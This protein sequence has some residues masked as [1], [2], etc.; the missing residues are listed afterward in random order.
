M[1]TINK[2]LGL[3]L[4][5]TVAAVSGCSRDYDAPPLNMPVYDGPDANITFTQLQE[6]YKDVADNTQ[7]LID[8]EYVI[9]GRVISSDA[10]G[11]IFKQIYIQNEEGGILLGVDQNNVS[12]YYKL[13]Q[14]VYVNLHGLYAVRYGGELQIGMGDTQANRI[15]WTTFTEH[16]QKDGWPD[17]AKIEP[18]SVQIKDLTD[19]MVNT[20]VKLEN[21]S[22]DDGGKLPFAED[23]MTSNRTVRSADGTATITLRTSGYSNFYKN[24]LPEGYGTLVGVVGKHRGEWQLMLRSYE[25]VIDFKAGEKP[26]PEPEDPSEN[27][28]GN[29]TIAEFAQKYAAATKDNPIKIEEDISLG[30]V[31]ISDDTDSNVFKKV[32][33]QDESGAITLGVDDNFISKAYPRGQYIHIDVKGLDAIIFGGVLQI[34]VAEANA[35]RMPLAEFSKRVS[36]GTSNNKIN[37]IKTSIDQLDGSMVNKLV[38]LDNVYFVDGGTLPYADKGKNVNRDIKDSKGNVLV[39]RNSGYSKFQAEMLPEGAISITGLLD[40]FNG[41]Y[42]LTIRDLNDVVKGG[43]VEPE[44]EPE[45]TPEEGVIFSETFGAKFDKGSSAWPKVGAFT[46]YDNKNVS[47]SDETGN[48]DIRN[49]K[50]LDNHVWLPANK[51]AEFKISGIKGSNQ[52]LELSFELAANLFNPGSEAD[53]GNVELWFNDTKL[54]IPSTIVT[55]EAG[56]SNKFRLITIEQAL[57]SNSDI[58]IKFV[59]SAEKNLV[60]FR[61]ANIKLSIKK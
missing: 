31:I 17:L 35:N 30:G 58:T 15:P 34:G 4:L 40:S 61:L 2:I 9:K 21:V 38:Q 42:Q 46:E 56:D 20:L 39:V 24:T 12:T 22:F 11:N 59:S 44:P 27:K 23:Q 43:V 14:E 49:T 48:A 18:K 3:L 41:A 45:P 47:Y 6:K 53:L 33:L 1:K 26:E 55:N 5:F 19:D 36:K 16:V 50:A 54:D 32:Y 8:V 51:D 60:G 7:E 28:P 10:S 37:V 25:D 57:E 29:T 52:K 13:G